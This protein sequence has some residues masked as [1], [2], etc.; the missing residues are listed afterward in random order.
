LAVCSVNLRM[1]FLY[2]LPMLANVAALGLGSA[3][4][5]RPGHRPGGTRGNGGAEGR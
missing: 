4:L 2:L 1:R 5:N 3:M